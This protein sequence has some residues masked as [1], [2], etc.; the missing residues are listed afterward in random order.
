MSPAAALVKRFLDAMAA[1]D[2]QA[3]ADCVTDDVERVGPFGDAHLGREEYVRFISGLLPT[4][5]GYSM[6]V[7]RVVVSADE[8]VVVAELS[9]TVELDGRPVVTQEA[10]VFDLDGT[11]QQIGHIRIYV[12]R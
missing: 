10:L 3:M 9:E 1:H 12:Q 4:L 8:R 6:D 7:A 5:A 11:A 2:W